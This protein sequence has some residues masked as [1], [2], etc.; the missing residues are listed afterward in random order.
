METTEKIVEAYTRYVKGWAT[1]PNIKCPGQYE[2][3]LLAVD[4][5]TGERFHIESGVSIS[6]G[7]S[8]LTAK[9]FSEDDLK[10]RTKK[11]HQRRT[12][13]YF[14][15]RKFAAK[16][17]VETLRRYGFEPGNYTKVIVTWAATDEAKHEAEANS[18]Q[19]WYFPE[20]MAEL[21]SAF[22]DK[23]TYFT[24]DTLRTLHLYAK[25]L[26]ADIREIQEVM[27]RKLQGE[28]Q[29]KGPRRKAPSTE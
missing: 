7:F 3:D 4:P 11:A 9:P 5:K 20:I 12:L 27:R 16:G 1:I 17:V 26:E 6:G 13:G 10:I 14:V 24:D 2:I 21:S 29:K 19:L 15:K 25:V 8:K 28:W 23:R 18:V 22:K